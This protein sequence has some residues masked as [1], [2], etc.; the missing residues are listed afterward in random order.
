[1]NINISKRNLIAIC[2]AVLLCTVVYTIVFSLSLKNDMNEFIAEVNQRSGDFLSSDP[3]PDYALD[4]Q[5]SYTLIECDKKI[6]IYNTDSSELLKIL[7]VYVATLP[8]ADQTMLTEG[9]C[10]RSRA[11]LVSLIEDYTS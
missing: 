5:D 3:A 10:V 7:D 8:C 4:L 9:I 2:A 6:G 1:M 11:E